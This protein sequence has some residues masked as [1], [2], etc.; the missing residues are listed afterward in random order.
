MFRALLA[1]GLAIVATVPILSQ[2]IIKIDGIAEPPELSGEPKKIS[3]PTEAERKL[4]EIV[5]HL[6]DEKEARSALPGLNRFIEEYPH[7]S[8]AS[9]L[10][11]TVEA[12]ILN[13]RDFASIVAD[14]RAAMSNGDASIYN[15]TDYY[16]LLGKIAIERAEYEGAADDLEKAMRRD[17]DSADRMFNIE[18]V[19]PEMTS[20]FCSW[21]LTDLNTLVARFPGDY[22]IRLFRGLYYE[23][24]TTFKEEYYAKAAQ[25]FQEAALLNPKSPLPPYFVGQLHSKASFWTKKA[26]ASDAGRDEPIKNAVQDYTNA[27]KLDPHFLEAYEQRA[28][29]YL[30]LKQ[31]SQAIKDFD[32]VLTLN[33][34]YASAYFDRGIAKLESGQYFAA[35]LDFGDAIRRKN[36]GDS[37]LSNLYEGLGD[38]HVKLGNYRDAVVDYSKAIERQLAN[39]TFLLS[40]KQFRGLYPEYDKASDEA[41]LRKLNAL[42]WPQFEYGVFAE[43]LKKNGKWEISLLNGLYEKRSYSYLRVGD[44]RRGVLDIN[45]IVKGMPNFADSTDRWRVLGKNADGETYYLDAKSAEFPATDPVR[46]WIKTAGKKRTQT[47]AYEIDCRGRRL[48]IGSEVTYDQDNKVVNTS[49]LSGGWQGVVPD[50]IGEQL[51]NGACYNN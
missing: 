39:Q 14:V 21:N 25:E 35:T 50:T 10:R 32:T 6:K 46:F 5:K 24:F 19:E 31:Y 27:I 3:Q 23:F 33:P 29:S 42:F 7:Y 44:Y 8:D 26:W 20:K 51:Y 36:E 15:T 11:A 28:S 41:V 17:L 22:R 1:C 38:A 13:S 40:L 48:S 16:S 45:R 34:E 47:A 49:E 30:N 12:C 2:T 37:F 4:F 18:G 43:Q 9:F